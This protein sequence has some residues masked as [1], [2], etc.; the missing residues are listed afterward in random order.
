MCLLLPTRAAEYR[1]FYCTTRLSQ[2][3]ASRAPAAA[4]LQLLPRRQ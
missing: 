2:A 3:L 4:T 1:V